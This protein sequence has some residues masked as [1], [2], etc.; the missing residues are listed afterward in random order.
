MHA[1]NRTKA[2]GVPDMRTHDL[3]NHANVSRRQGV[4]DEVAYLVWN[5]ARPGLNQHYN[6]PDVAPVRSALELWAT[7]VEAACSEEAAKQL[8]SMAA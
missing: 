2:F 1:R 5:H 6:T 7:Y 4:P 3:Q 8:A